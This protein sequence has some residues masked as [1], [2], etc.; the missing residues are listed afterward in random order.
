MLKEFLS[1]GVVS[2]R[3]MDLGHPKGVVIV[4]WM[5]DAL[6]V[7]QGAGADGRR[8]EREERLL[9]CQSQQLVTNENGCLELACVE[10]CLAPFAQEGL[11]LTVVLITIRGHVEANG[12]LSS[13]KNT[14][15]ATMRGQGCTEPGRIAVVQCAVVQNV[16]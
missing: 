2:G 6:V 1:S 16:L 5:R 15:S 10:G 7:D 14:S 9:T 3:K 8:T 4:V 13:P 12:P 11:H